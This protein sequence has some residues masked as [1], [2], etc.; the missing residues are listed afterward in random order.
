MHA[1]DLLVAA[2][3]TAWSLFCSAASVP[4]LKDIGVGS[5]EVIY[6]V[7]TVLLCLKQGRIDFVLSL[8]QIFNALKHEPNSR[9]LLFFF[10]F[11]LPKSER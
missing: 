2:K 3:Y 7:G 4:L 9:K 1:V 6:G 5:T 8:V 11:P 10:F